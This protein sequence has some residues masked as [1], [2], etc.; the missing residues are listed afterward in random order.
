MINNIWIPLVIWAEGLT[1]IHH[2]KGFLKGILQVD[3]HMK[4]PLEVLPG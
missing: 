3:T 2:M 4:V 1:E